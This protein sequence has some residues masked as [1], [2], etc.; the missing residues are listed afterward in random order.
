MHS[1][2]VAV[3]FLTIL[4]VPRGTWSSPTPFGRA[5]AWFPCVG[6]AIGALLAGVT[7]GLALALPGALVAALVVALG[8][9]LTGGLHL[10]GLMDACDGLFSVRTPEQRLAIMRDSHTGAFGVLAAICIL[11]VKF[12]ALSALLVEERTFLLS[13]LLLAP[14]LSR[15][16]MAL[17]SICFPYGRSG[18]SLG[19]S[20]HSTAGRFQLVAASASAVL[21]TGVVCAT[22]RAPAW[23]GACALALSAT[24]T[25]LLARF[26]L[27]RIGGLTGD[28]YGAINEVVEVVVLALFTLQWPR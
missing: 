12:G 23:L 8:V 20:F 28:V 21:I 22:L 17:A 4:P 13:G 19:S 10:D 18:E 25:V 9:L 24:T 15:W 27:R 6:L 14:A 16:A 26:A 11:L 1:L 2:A 7:L 3:G 5:F